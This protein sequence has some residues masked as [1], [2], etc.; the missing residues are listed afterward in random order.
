[1]KEIA[2]ALLE[3]KAVNIQPDFSIRWASGI[4]SPIYCDN[5]LVISHPKVR[6]LVT[7]GFKKYIFAQ[8]A[9]TN[10]IAGTATAGIPHASFVAYAT[11]LPMV[12]VRA[13]AKEHG[14]KKV[15]EGDFRAGQKVLVIED[16]ISTGQSSLKVVKNLR[17]SGLEVLAVV[18]I[19]TYGLEKARLA[20]QEAKVPF[21]SLT[22][23]DELLEVAT[24]ENYIQAADVETVK[25]FLRD[26]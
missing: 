26:L 10:L 3:I 25:K 17:E 7:E 12:Y 20:F 6:K 9:N 19:F 1:M 15:I 13:E 14:A 5:R 23:I 24:S 21:T 4:Q 2:K 18:S 22:N 11:D 16:L 8:F